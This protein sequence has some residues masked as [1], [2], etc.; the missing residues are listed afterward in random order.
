LT[1]FPITYDAPAEVISVRVKYSL[2]GGFT[3][4]PARGTPGVLPGTFDWDVPTP[5]K[6]KT[7]ALVKVIGL[8][9]SNVRIGADTSDAPFTIDV[10]SIT[11]P[12]ADAIVTKGTLGF[13]V[14]WT[15]N[16]TKRPVSSAKVFYTFGIS[17]IWKPANG[18]VVDPLGS[19]TWNVPSPAKAKIVKLKVVLKD[20]LGVIVGTAVSGAFIVQ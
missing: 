10:V 18:T 5:V 15:T 6:N 16:V 8:N 14:T 20:A 3:W 11:A 19:F 17:G 2:D 1:P 12:V 13:P 4:L 7:K 9:G